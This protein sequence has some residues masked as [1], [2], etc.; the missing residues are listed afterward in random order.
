MAAL[1]RHVFSAMRLISGRETDVA[2]A[3]VCGLRKPIGR[4]VGHRT[5]N[6]WVTTGRVDVEYETLPFRETEFF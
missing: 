4:I 6:P 3:S 5:T 2:G 1:R